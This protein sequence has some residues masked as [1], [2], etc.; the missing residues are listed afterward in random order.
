MI[1]KASQL[2]NSAI[3]VGVDF[4]LPGW[5]WRTRKIKPNTK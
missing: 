2:K 3:I 5:D 4:N 1:R